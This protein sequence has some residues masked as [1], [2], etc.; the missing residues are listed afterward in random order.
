MKY[1]L[2]I[3]FVFSCNVAWGECPNTL[4][5]LMTRDRLIVKNF[6][7]IE[8]LLK[9]IAESLKDE[10]LRNMYINKSFLFQSS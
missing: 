4:E 3:I 10:E 2:I 5:G 9:E 1:F 6:L 8:K 7:Q